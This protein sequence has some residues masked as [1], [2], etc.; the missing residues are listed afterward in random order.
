M[1]FIAAV[2]YDRISAP[3]IIYGLI[4]SLLCPESIG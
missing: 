4:I 2:Y 1:T 3:W